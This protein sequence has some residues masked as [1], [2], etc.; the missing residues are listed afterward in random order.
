[1]FLEGLERRLMKWK[2]STSEQLGDCFLQMVNL[3]KYL[4]RVFLLIYFTGFSYYI[5]G[6][7]KQLQRLASPLQ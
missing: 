7:H 3:E 5:L 6:I 1:M 4:Q 2:T